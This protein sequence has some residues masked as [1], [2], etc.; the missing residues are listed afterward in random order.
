MLGRSIK[1]LQLPREELVILTKVG[2]PTEAFPAR[3]AV[4]AE[5]T[6]V[7]CAVAPAYSI[8][9]HGKNPED[10]GNINQHGLSRK[11]CLPVTG[12]YLMSILVLVPSS[13]SLTR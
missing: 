12:E 9:L 1:D 5:P 13:T 10:V 11:V 8:N 2:T 6:Q 7:Y 3:H 4:W